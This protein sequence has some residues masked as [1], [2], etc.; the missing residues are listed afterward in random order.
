MI[1]KAIILCGGTGSRMFPATKTTNKQLLPVYDKPMFYYPLSLLMLV[2]IK[3]YLFII[4]KGQKKKFLKSIGSTKDLGINIEFKEQDKPNGLPEAFILG[5]KFIGK[6]SVLM[7]LGDNFFYGSMLS[8]VIKKT[9]SV[10][11]GANIYLYPSK[12]T[13]SYGVVELKKSGEIN[14]IIEKPAFTKSNLVITGMYIFDNKVI[15]YAKKLKPS[16]R[17]ELEMVDLI[18]IYKKKNN[19]NLVKLGRGSAWLD[20]G[21]YDD[22]FSASSF[23]KNIED[24][25]DYK[26]G[27]IE[28]IALNNK[29]INKHNIKNRIKFNKN[30]NYSKY[31]AELIK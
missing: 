7:I 9:L 4:N 13:S 20:V 2:G 6:D 10:K 26:I 27:C 1:K 12:N 18:N 19:L 25:Q 11:N 31:L 22:L 23:I 28:E 3:N 17:N 5:E 30:S 24:R 21:N 14:K 8:P 29:W 15:K 16:K